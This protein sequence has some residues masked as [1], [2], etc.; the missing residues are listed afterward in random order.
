VFAAISLSRAFGV[1]QNFGSLVDY[2]VVGM[3]IFGVG[4]FVV[5]G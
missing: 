3:S 4:L 2:F 5:L 1:K